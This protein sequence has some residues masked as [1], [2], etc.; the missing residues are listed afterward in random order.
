MRR[1]LFSQLLGFAAVLGLGVVVFAGTEARAA[2]Y[3][4]NVSLNRCYAYVSWYSG[5]QG[6][7]CD[8]PQ[9]KWCQ[10]V[11]PTGTF[12]YTPVTM[13]N[14]GSYAEIKTAADLWNAGQTPAT[15]G[16][17]LYLHLTSNSTNDIDVENI[18]AGAT[19]WWGDGDGI[20]RVTPEADDALE[21]EEL[22]RV[23]VIDVPR[24]RAGAVAREHDGER[25]ATALDAGD[26]C[27]STRKPEV[28]MRTG[29]AADGGRDARRPSMRGCCRSDASIPVASSRRSERRRLG[30][31]GGLL[32]ALS[33]FLLPAA[34]C[35]RSSVISCSTSQGRGCPGSRARAG[36]RPFSPRGA[37]R[38]RRPPSS[39][40][41]W[42][43]A[44]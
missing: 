5:L 33:A 36:G 19:G 14:W 17:S 23:V 18:N 9:A 1:S 25:D 6:S 38:A 4:G 40:R 31:R 29:H 13:R 27:V 30:G 44:P 16:N 10:R 28:L 2:C 26:A 15:A 41:T 24:R 21:A 37:W 34:C 22:Q 12:A 43:T 39:S 35:L 3:G 11:N 8:T 20:R 7:T 42:G 32:S